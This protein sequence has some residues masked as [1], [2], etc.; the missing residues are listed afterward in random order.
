MNMLAKMPEKVE[1]KIDTKVV[2]LTFI[3]FPGFGKSYFANYIFFKVYISPDSI[4]T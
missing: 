2:F 3:G 4:S 1:Q